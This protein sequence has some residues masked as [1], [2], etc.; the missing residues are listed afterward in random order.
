MVGGIIINILWPC[1]ETQSLADDL[2]LTICCS[3]NKSCTYFECSPCGQGRQYETMGICLA[4]GVP[5]V[6]FV[7]LKRI[8]ENEHHCAA[9]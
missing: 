6:L 2:S 1:Q 8:R 5:S 3:E 7:L 9:N 4:L